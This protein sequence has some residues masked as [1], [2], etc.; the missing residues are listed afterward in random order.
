MTWYLLYILQPKYYSLLSPDNCKMPQRMIGDGRTVSK[1]LFFPT[2][3]YRGVKSDWTHK[4]LRHSKPLFS[5]YWSLY[6]DVQMSDDD[7]MS[8]YRFT[9]WCEVC[10]TVCVRLRLRL[11]VGGRLRSKA[12]SHRR[13]EFPKSLNTAVGLFGA[14]SES[15]LSA[16]GTE[17]SHKHALTAPSP[18]LYLSVCLS[19]CPSLFPKSPFF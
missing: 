14:G 12:G 2:E 11:G 10:F 8:I 18:S 9:V 19:S 17:R 7:M 16:G 5:V 6:R 1:Q 13:A 15:A 4:L 3:F